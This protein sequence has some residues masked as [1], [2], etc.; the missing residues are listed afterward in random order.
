MHGGILG[1]ADKEI[2]GTWNEPLGL[3]GSAIRRMFEAPNRHLLLLPLEI[4]KTIAC[5]FVAA[6]TSP[7]YEGLR[8]H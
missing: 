4:A 2:A 5:A 8:F 3:S 7:F 6:I 1:G